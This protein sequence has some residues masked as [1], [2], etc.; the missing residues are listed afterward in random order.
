LGIIIA[1]MRK[2]KPS[3]KVV[4]QYFEVEKILAKRFIRGSA[5][6]L[7]KWKD[8]EEAEATWEDANNLAS[9]LDMVLEFE[10]RAEAEAEEGLAEGQK[11]AFDTQEMPTTTPFFNILEMKYGGC[12]KA[13][14]DEHPNEVTTEVQGSGRFAEGITFA[15]DN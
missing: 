8:F 9:V 14:A 5:E 4:E 7:V 2:G 13:K 11:E 1:N 6:Y 15:I 3:Q 12:G 10:R